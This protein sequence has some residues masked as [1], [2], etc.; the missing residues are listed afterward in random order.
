MENLDQTL[1]EM[2]EKT[3]EISRLLLVPG[4]ETLTAQDFHQA[5]TVSV[6]ELIGLAERVERSLAKLDRE[7]PLLP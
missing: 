5:I 6:M 2:E 4:V 7:D 3:V 1:L